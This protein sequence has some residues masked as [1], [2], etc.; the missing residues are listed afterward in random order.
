[1]TDSM[2]PKCDNCGNNRGNKTRFCSA[3]C[4][5]D[6]AFRAMGTTA[7]RR[8]V[9]VLFQRMIRAEYGAKPAG[10]A[11]AVQSGKIVA[12]DRQMGQCVCVTCGRVAKWDAG[13]RVMH[14]GH[15]VGGRSASIVFDERNVAPQCSHCNVYR[16]GAAAEFAIWMLA[17]HG[18]DVIDELRQK[19][20][21]APAY[22]RSALVDMWFKFALRLK[23]A[24]NTMRTAQ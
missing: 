5:K 21:T 11:S 23:T 8:R 9:A 24:Q 2:T 12:V 14:T 4:E 7:A 6:L 15:F 3:R 13:L 19:R 1:M 22:D 18:S 17:T 20:H 16:H 10:P